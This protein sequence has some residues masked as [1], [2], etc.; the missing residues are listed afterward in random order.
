MKWPI[1]NDN[2]NV[3][4]VSH[5]MCIPSSESFANCFFNCFSL[6]LFEQLFDG[7]E[8]RVRHMVIIYDESNSTIYFV[9]QFLDV[10]LHEEFRFARHSN[11]CEKRS[12][13]QT[14][15]V[16]CCYF[17]H[18]IKCCC[19]RFALKCQTEFSSFQMFNIIIIHLSITSI[20]R[21]EIKQAI[22]IFF[23]RMILTVE[24]TTFG[25]NN[26]LFNRFLLFSSHF[27]CEQKSFNL[28]L[29]LRFPTQKRKKKMRNNNEIRRESQNRISMTQS[30]ESLTHVLF[31]ICI[32]DVDGGSVP[33]R[34]L[35]NNNMFNFEA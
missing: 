24:L 11:H 10:K 7:K 28:I 4:Q 35:R 12:I 3:F 18:R 15:A 25:Q 17:F 33:N 8:H 16:P 2:K 5:T 27:S 23:F 31:L 22:S 34:F 6:F 29:R 13:N 14:N 20:D 9:R 30:I 32:Y 19:C 21:S 1:A 26:L